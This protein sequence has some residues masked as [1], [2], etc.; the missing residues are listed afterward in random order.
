MNI[1]RKVLEEVQQSMDMRKKEFKDLMG[2][3]IEEVLSLNNNCTLPEDKIK[4]LR[5]SIQIF[6]LCLFVNWLYIT[7]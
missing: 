1:D 7:L 4:P 2:S 3:K 5:V 6:R